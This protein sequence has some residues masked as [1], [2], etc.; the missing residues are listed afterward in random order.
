MKYLKG[1]IHYCVHD[2]VKIRLCTLAGKPAI[3]VRKEHL[4]IC[5]T[6]RLLHL[7]KDIYNACELHNTNTM[8]DEIVQASEH[9]CSEEE[10]TTTRR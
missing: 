8:I 10:Y 1:I 2:G 3:A 9:Y 4:E 6:I 7:F 5:C